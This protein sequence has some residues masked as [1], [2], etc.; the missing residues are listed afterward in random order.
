MASLPERLYLEA[1]TNVWPRDQTPSTLNIILTILCM[2][3]KVFRCDLFLDPATINQSDDEFPYS[4]TNCPILG[5]EMNCRKS[6][7][8]RCNKHLKYV[9]KYRHL[10][11]PENKVKHLRLPTAAIFLEGLNAY[12]LSYPCPSI[13][14]TA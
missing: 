13:E 10:N 12:R 2:Y 9:V 1:G 6:E 8:N 4:I 5:N 7:G 3:F 11:I 14:L